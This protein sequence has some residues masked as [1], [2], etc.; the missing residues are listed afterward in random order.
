MLLFGLTPCVLAAQ[1]KRFGVV[2]SPFDVTV[3]AGPPVASRCSAQVRATGNAGCSRG[4]GVDEERIQI[5][6]NASTMHAHPS[7]GPHFSRSAPRGKD[8][9]TRWCARCKSLLA[10]LCSVHDWVALMWLRSPLVRLGPRWFK[11]RAMATA[12]SAALAAPT[13]S[14]KSRL[15]WSRTPLTRWWRTQ[16]PPLHPTAIAIKVAAV[17]RP[18]RRHRRR[19]STTVTTT[20]VG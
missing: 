1:G 8:R 2:G 12:T 15:L 18:R 6:H 16:L 5:T 11:Q 13:S 20:Q 7:S 9:H 4:G 19:G 17:A 10:L 14:S 3:H